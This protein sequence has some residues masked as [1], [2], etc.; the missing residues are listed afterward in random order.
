MDESW[1][2]DALKCAIRIERSGLHCQVQEMQFHS[3]APGLQLPEASS[4]RPIPQNT[5]IN[6]NA[7]ASKKKTRSHKK[8]TLE[9]QDSETN[10]VRLHLGALPSFRQRP[11]MAERPRSESLHRSIRQRGTGGGHTNGVVEPCA[12]AKLEK[13]PVQALCHGKPRP[14]LSISTITCRHDKFSHDGG[15]YHATKMAVE[16]KRETGTQKWFIHCDRQA[17]CHGWSRG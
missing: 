8:K 10:M 1:C 12:Q 2:A 17:R 9:I 11:P 3:S 13:G 6:K 4:E 14:I 5:D 16:T 7:R 15:T